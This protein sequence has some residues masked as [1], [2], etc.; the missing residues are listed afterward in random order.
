MVS[1]IQTYLLMRVCP[2]SFLGRVYCFFCKDSHKVWNSV[3]EVWKFST[4][5]LQRYKK[6]K[7]EERRRGRERKEDQHLY[8]PRA[9]TCYL[10]DVARAD[11]R[12]CKLKQLS[13]IEIWLFVVRCAFFSQLSKNFTHLTFYF[14][15][16]INNWIDSFGQSNRFI[17]WFESIQIIEWIDA[18]YFGH[19]KM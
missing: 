17:R 10:L 8:T 1:I 2:L 3:A 4:I 5:W 7:N 11:S 6:V 16:P 19:H 15:C 12:G 18:R 13:V 9:H 14:I